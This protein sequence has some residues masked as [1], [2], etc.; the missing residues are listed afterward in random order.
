MK[1]LFFIIV[2]ACTALAVM[3]GVPKPDAARA[4]QALKNGSGAVS[5]PVSGDRAGQ[6]SLHQFMREHKV[7]PSDNR[8]TKKAPP[9]L[10]PENMAVNRIVAVEAQALEFDE[11]NNVTVNDTIYSLGWGGLVTDYGD[12]VFG[13]RGFYGSYTLPFYYDEYDI[14]YLTSCVLVDTTIQGSAVGGAVL[15][16]RTDTTRWYAFY[17]F[18]AFFNDDFADIPGTVYDDGSILFDNSFVIYF[19][20]IYDTYRVRQ[21]G[22]VVSLFSSDTVAFIS[23]LFSNIYLLQ[24]N[25]M[26]ECT[27]RQDGSMSS[28][29]RL[30]LI[31]E[32]YLQHQNNVVVVDDVGHGSGSGSTADAPVFAGGG[33]SIMGLHPR[34]IDPRKP[35]H[36]SPK[37]I[38]MPDLK[39]MVE[40]GAV[41]GGPEEVNLGSVEGPR[42]LNANLPTN[43]Q[44]PASFNVVPGGSVFTGSMQSPVYMYQLDDSTIC[45]YNLF[46]LGYTMNYLTMSLDGEMTFPPQV[47]FYERN[48]DEDFF[49]CSLVGDSL[50]LGNTGSASNDTIRWGTTLPHSLN[51]EYNFRYS[52]NRLYFTDG[53][54]F[55]IGNAEMPTIEK[56]NGKW[57]Y[58]FTGV[59]QEE[60]AEVSLFT[61]DYDDNGDM[62]NF[63]LVDNPYTVMISDVDQVIHLAA[64]AD[65]FNIGKNVSE[66][67]LADFSIP[68]LIMMGDV[69]RDRLLTI[70]DVTT[71]IRHVLTE[72][73]T[74]T[75]NFNPVSADVNH[76]GELTIADVTVLIH[77]VLNE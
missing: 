41:T 1:H 9:R 26:H 4:R 42:I 43:N 33:L 65:G 75:S 56:V 59:T 12:D 54:R 15:R 8:L 37:P 2:C 51:S 34:P 58:V 23:P 38:T 16:T 67:Y 36:K 14:P 52:N 74:M 11:W 6:V 30:P 66:L 31:Y 71:L 47:L 28:T 62:I 5:T 7:T 17:T 68:G 46:G 21:N 40:P 18:D 25:G 44:N 27:Y 29:S 50:L 49:N 72:D 77:M 35:N 57:C 3:A 45:V 32:E 10:S 22:Q 48:L 39:D 20:E 76:D 73:V 63:T 70:A 61:F 19:E 60:G 13:V 24:P 53:N 55:L 69:N 64:L